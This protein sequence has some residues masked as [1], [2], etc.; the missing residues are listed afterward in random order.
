MANRKAAATTTSGR[1]AKKMKT[2]K[3]GTYRKSN[4]TYLN[5]DGKEVPYEDASDQDG[6]NNDEEEYSS[7]DDSYQIPMGNL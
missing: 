2:T 1:K 5:S 6:I 4:D 7:S 3:T